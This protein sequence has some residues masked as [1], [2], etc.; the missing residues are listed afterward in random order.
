MLTAPKAVI[1][2][3]ILLCAVSSFYQIPKSTLSNY[4]KNLKSTNG[5][6]FNYE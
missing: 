6:V 1:N 3:E 5:N 2:R 4:V